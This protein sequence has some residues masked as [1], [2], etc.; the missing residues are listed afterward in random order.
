MMSTSL[1]FMLLLES[2]YSG[3][4]VVV[5]A[6]AVASVSPVV[7]MSSSTGVYSGS[8]IPAVVGVPSVP[9]GSYAAV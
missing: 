3:V 8:V 5:G 2:L 1:E 6:T 9:A 4:S 7:N